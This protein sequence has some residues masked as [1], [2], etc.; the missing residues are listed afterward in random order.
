VYTSPVDSAAASRWN[1]SLAKEFPPAKEKELIW[2]RVM[3]ALIPGGGFAGKCYLLV[4]A[5]RV[6]LCCGCE[7]ALVGGSCLLAGFFVLAS[8]TISYYF[9]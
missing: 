5:V 9:R 6:L 4:L 1:S 3:R 2:G 8:F 7:A